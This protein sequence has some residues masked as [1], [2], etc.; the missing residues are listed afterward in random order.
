MRALGRYDILRRL[1]SSRL[2]EVFAGRRH[3]L[4]GLPPDGR[5]FALTRLSQAVVEQ[6]GVLGALEAEV[7][8]ARRFAHPAA[9]RVVGLERDDEGNPFLAAELVAGVTLGAVLRR[10][11]AD[12]VR[13]RECLA[14]VTVAE[15][16][17]AIEALH[18]RGRDAEG[19][20]I[21]HGGLS[22][23]SILLEDSGR[24]RTVGIG[25]GRARWLIPVT[26]ARHLAYMPP[27]ALTHGSTPSPAA[28]IYALGLILFE[29]L[30]GQVPFGGLE[31]EALRAAIIRGERALD[32]R[33]L[34]VPAPARVAIQAMLALR[35]G[36]RPS[37]LGEVLPALRG[38]ANLELAEARQEIVRCLRALFPDAP[39]LRRDL[40]VSVSSEGSLGDFDA[41][42][43]PVEEEP[44]IVLGDG[45]RASP[46]DLEPRSARAPETV[47]TAVSSRHL[48]RYRI[49]TLLGRSAT[50]SSFFARDA[51]LEREL[52]IKALDPTLVADTRL[53]TEEWVRLFKR[54]ARMAARVAHG[55]LPVLYDAGTH[56]GCYFAVYQWFEGA[57]LARKVNAGRPMATADVYRVMLDVVDAL[58]YLHSRGILHGDIRAANILVGPRGAKLLDFSMAMILG[59]DDH[60]LR[61]CNMYAL[62][63]ECLDG[64]PY[65]PRSEQ[66][67]L[68][69]MLY[70]MLVGT[71]PFRG[72]DDRALA[73]ALRSTT[74]RPPQ[75]IVPTADPALSEVCMRLLERD[76]MLRFESMGA[77]LDRIRKQNMRARTKRPSSA[78]DATPG[79]DAPLSTADLEATVGS[80]ALARALLALLQRTTAISP[81]SYDSST[82]LNLL[83]PRAD[84]IAAA[85]GVL[86]R[87][88]RSGDS[89]IVASIAIAARILSKRLGLAATSD[90]LMGCIP[91]A[92]IQLLTEVDGLREA[93][94]VESAKPAYASTLV[95]AVYAIERYFSATNPT[96]LRERLSP[97]RALLALREDVGSKIGEAVFGA[98][99]DYL[100]EII[101]ALDW[102]SDSQSENSGPRSSSPD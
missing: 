4:D 48:G 71:R 45:E 66:F 74:P 5:R 2:G 42:R 50:T 54:E 84:P 7:N 61:L 15:V 36:D 9:A 100:R 19:A 35:P 8:G 31:G 22:P 25:W 92:I 37:R 53:K 65:S 68:G 13:L 1:G 60:P 90:P 12:T 98:L 97:R 93:P 85:G 91:D 51:N 83:E 24:G 94:V 23:R 88:K 69:S 17:E 41:P 58:A 33:L 20:T 82:T 6:P 18:E 59:E 101:S 80:D 40:P 14:L 76:P 56:E 64:L 34:G 99:L 89:E 73:G 44:G 62:A 16:V 57:V 70:E 87:L 46:G 67:A 28:D 77:V 79:A 11:Q 81:E 10:A 32:G 27:E 39:E 49:E 86:R 102:P 26:A 63:P 29:T 75:A 52:F 95:Q 96:D 21:C 3:L 30:S 38:L 72:P 55:A 43:A 78:H 47:T